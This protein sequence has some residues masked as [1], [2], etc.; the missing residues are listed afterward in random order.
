MKLKEE[1]IICDRCENYYTTPSGCGSSCF[2]VRRDG[3]FVFT[4]AYFEERE[5]GEKLSCKGFEKIVDQKGW[6]LSAK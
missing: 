2:R 6:Y 1:E 3:L 5:K 4:P